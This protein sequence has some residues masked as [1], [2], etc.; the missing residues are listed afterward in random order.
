ML[1]I[2]DLQSSSD[3]RARGLISPNERWGLLRQLIAELRFPDARVAVTEDEIS[4]AQ[5]VCYRLYSIHVATMMAKRLG[6]SV[7]EYRRA[8]DAALMW[9]PTNEE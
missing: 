5:D 8:L 6:V 7:D 9:R 2:Y 1:D 4:A 3:Y